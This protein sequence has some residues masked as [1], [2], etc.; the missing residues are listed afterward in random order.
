M[1]VSQYG[2]NAR[3]NE[4]RIISDMNDK[5][6]RVLCIDGGGMRGLY[7]AVLLSTL[8][9]RFDEK[10]AKEFPDLGKAFD[11]I[12][13][14]STGAILACGLAAGVTLNKIEMLYSNNGKDIFPDPTPSQNENIKLPIWAFAHLK[15][16]AANKAKLEEILK[17]TF[18]KE[19]IKSLYE[20]RKIGLCIPAVDAATYKAWVF[21]TPHNPL[22]HRDDNYSLVDVC[23]AS[24]A[25]PILFP[26]AAVDHPE[27]KGEKDYFVDGGLWANNPVLVGLTEAL[28]LTEGKCS[29]DILSVGTCDRPSGDPYALNNPDWGLAQ[30]RVGINIVEMA[31]S[32][33][34]YGYSETAKFLGTQLTKLGVATRV[35]R[36]EQTNKSPEQYSA[37]NID[38]GDGVAIDTLKKMARMDADAIHSKA[39]SADPGNL[40]MVSEIFSNLS[41]LSE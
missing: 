22:K 2:Y 33:Q 18:Q 23:L 13:G 24:A 10:F 37:I 20:R 7:S 32:A 15:K 5:P 35:V 4:E 36:L 19:T 28:S 34:S 21:K 29:L 3:Q 16:P 11:L 27:R 14:T 41:V 1:K 31:I 17:S 25:A 30:W 6:F 40:K 38:R 26:L 12:C 8:A 9:H 39:I